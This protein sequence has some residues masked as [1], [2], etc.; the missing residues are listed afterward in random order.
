MDFS[1]RGIIRQ[2]LKKVFVHLFFLSLFFPFFFNGTQ[3]PV[4]RRTIIRQK[5]EEVCIMKN[6]L[7]LVLILLAA[8]GILRAAVVNDDAPL[9]GRWDFR[10]QQ[11]WAVDSAGDDILVSFGSLTVDENGRVYFLERKHSKVFVCDK[12][13]TFL[14][15]F[16]SKGEGPG[17]FKR[18]IRIFLV[19]RYLIVWDN[20]RRLHYFTKEGKFFRSFRFGTYYS[21][22]GFTDI[23]SFVSLRS[24]PEKESGPTETLEKYD[25]KTE[26]AVTLDEVIADKPVKAS[27]GTSR[28]SITV[29]V[30]DED[31]TPMV[32]LGTSPNALYYG[33]NDAYRIK[34]TDFDGT[35]L[36]TFGIDGRKRKPVPE[37]YKKNLVSKM[38]REIP[39]QVK[40]QIYNKIPDTSTFFSKIHADEQGLIYVYVTD[41][42]NRQGQEMDIFSPKGQYL[43]RAEVRVPEGFTLRGEVT[44]HRDSL[45]AMVEDEEGER[46]L[47]KYKINRPRR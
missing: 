6:S 27:N 19:K 26:K 14:F 1:V 36:L 34:K 30:S 24:D 21:P 47:I 28:G 10:L 23:T 12:E 18:A 39:P 11:Q 17:E 20:G 2:F 38:S 43:Y 22:R 37:A 41:L 7:R 33:R 5:T 46:Q 42:G 29:S 35:G 15:S 16:G 31:T 25:L 3:R 45:F 40:K 44:L 32:I 9:K 8:A 4:A 13:G